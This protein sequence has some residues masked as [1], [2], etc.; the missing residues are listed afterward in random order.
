MKLLNLNTLV[1]GFGAL[2]LVTACDTAETTT[3]AGPAESCSV[4][5]LENGALMTESPEPVM[6][7]CRPDPGIVHTAERQMIV[8]VFVPLRP[9]IITGGIDHDDRHHVGLA[10]LDEREHFEALV[11]GAE[12]A[13]KQSHR[14]GLR[15]EHQLA[16]E[17]IAEQ[18]QFFVTGDELVGVG[19]EWQANRHPERRF[20]ASPVM[21]G[22]HDPV[23]GACDDHPA[24]TGDDPAKVLGGAVVGM[25]RRGAG[26]A[27]HRDLARLGEGSK[28]LHG[29]PQLLEAAA[30]KL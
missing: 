29:V 14:I 22:P 1:V 16:G 23:A 15:N 12:A 11:V 6:A 19:L 20:P 24:A 8:D 10:G 25:I 21:A 9:V 5:Q 4:T 27:E 7:M 26:R 3:A 13:G 2:A 30:D 17:E 18:D 28:D